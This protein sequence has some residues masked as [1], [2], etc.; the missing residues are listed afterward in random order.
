MNNGVSKNTGINSSPVAGR[1]GV[2]GG[3]D[4][5]PHG[6]PGK[7]DAVEEV[8]EGVGSTV[9]VLEKEVIGRFG[10]TSEGGAKGAEKFF[11]AMGSGIDTSR[12]Y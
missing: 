5:V 4:I 6:I 12:I 9:H 7:L 1:R 8:D 10:C 3:A 11:V 2:G